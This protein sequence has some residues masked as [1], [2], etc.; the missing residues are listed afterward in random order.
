M[1][2]QSGVGRDATGLR[3]TRMHPSQPRLAMENFHL[4]PF[5]SP[6]FRAG[7][8]ATAG[9]AVWLASILAFAT[10]APAQQQYFDALS[11]TCAGEAKQLLTTRSCQTCHTS[12]AGRESGSN[13]NTAVAL[14]FNSS[15]KSAAAACAALAPAV[16]VPQANHAAP[17][18]GTL[19]I[20]V[21]LPAGKL[22]RFTLTATDADPGSRVR[23]SFRSEAGS[24]KPAGAKLK[25]LPRKSGKFS[26]VFSWKPK[27]SQ[28]GQTFTLI[29]T[30]TDNDRPAH[31]VTQ[32]VAFSISP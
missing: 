30:A 27:R 6:K 1:P 11:R 12:S 25:S 7:S 19:P 21:T 23:F 24:A 22:Y 2:A 17:V 29:F 16:T 10:E 26:A 20:A 18:M 31:S 3:P 28:A 4:N 9:R 13:A 15:G 8:G 5:R 32:A 14:A